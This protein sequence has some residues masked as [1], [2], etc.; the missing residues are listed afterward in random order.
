MHFQI[1]VFKIQPQI[2]FPSLSFHLFSYEFCYFNSWFHNYTYPHPVHPWMC[3]KNMYP[4]WR[5]FLI[6]TVILCC[7]I[8]IPWL[9]ITHGYIFELPT[10]PILNL[11]VDLPIYIS[12]RTQIYKYIII[13]YIE[14]NDEIHHK[15]LYNVE[16][17]VLNVGRLVIIYINKYYERYVKC[18]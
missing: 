1:P 16:C 18:S 3:G 12:P 17:C 13:I 5:V 4:V 15:H 8:E 7:L 10:M 9:F 2:F 14:I 11:S 6:H